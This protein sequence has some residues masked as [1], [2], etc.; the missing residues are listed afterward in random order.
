MSGYFLLGQTSYDR[1]H[2]HPGEA[3]IAKRLRSD[4][5]SMKIA[6]AMF[7]PPEEASRRLSGEP[8]DV[9]VDA[10]RIIAVSIHGIEEDSSRESRKLSPKDTDRIDTHRRY[11]LDLLRRAA[12][13]GFSDFDRL[14]SN[15][16]FDSLTQTQEYSSFVSNLKQTLQD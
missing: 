7:G 16:F 9:L 1:H 8:A 14:E 6:S 15:P 13:S 4:I 12:D 3:A 2:Q 10:A 11:A 5:N